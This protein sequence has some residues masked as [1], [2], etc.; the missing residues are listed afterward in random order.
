[1]EENR[2]DVVLLA[3]PFQFPPR[4]SLALAYFKPILEAA[5]LREKTLYPMVRLCQLMGRQLMER[6]FQIGDITLFEEYIFSGLTGRKDTSDLDGYVA[7][8]CERF[9]SLDPDEWT[10]L[11]AEGI[12]CAT[13]LVEETAREICELSPAALCASSLFSQQN[14]SL[15]ILRRARELVPGLKTMMGGP[16]CSGKAGRAIL[17]YF[18]QVDAV[19]FGEG[20]EVFAEAVRGLIENGPLPYGVLRREDVCDGQ[21]DGKPM[22]YRLTKDLNGIVIPDFGDFEP[23]IQQIP[24]DMLPMMDDLY[25]KNLETVILVEGS[26]GCWWGQKHPC[27]FCTLNGERNVY[28]TKT[29][30]RIFDEIK[31]QITRYHTPYVEFTDNVLSQDVIRELPELL[32]KLPFPIVA[33]AEVKPNLKEQEVFALK[34]AGFYHIQA[35]IESLNGHLMRL[36]GKGNSPV[37]HLAFLKACRRSGIYPLW[38]IL[39]RIPGE[40]EEDYEMLFE[41]F[42]LISHLP[43]PTAFTRI[44]FERGSCYVEHPSQY[45]LELKPDRFYEY[46]FGKHEE[47]VRSF[48][49]YYEDVGGRESANLHAMKPFHDR[50]IQLIREWRNIYYREGGCHLVMYDRGS[51]LVIRDTR[52]VRKTPMIFLRGPMRALCLLCDRGLSRGEAVRKLQESWPEAAIEETVGFLKAYG[53]LV[54][55]EDRFL[56]LATLGEDG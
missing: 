22:P 29:P 32:K 12:R 9:P 31:Q 48:A 7:L 30:R 27:S 28:R 5:G 46:V 13:Q 2:P 50:L 51:Y 4:A 10:H 6:L 44:L 16:N 23:Y 56:T 11:I 20:D 42:P 55:L 24:K 34:Q 53:Y 38:N 52:P 14:A 33:M 49:L 8:C 26:R 35:G 15:A 39:Y 19:F 1:M 25:G 21:Y 41:L 47:I 43:P 17:K 45:G 3:A 54:E 37:G 40:R 18:P 36:M